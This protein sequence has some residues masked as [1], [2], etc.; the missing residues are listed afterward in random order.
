MNILPPHATRFWYAF[1]LTGLQFFA[2]YLIL[3]IKRTSPNER[4]DLMKSA[5]QTN[6]Q[7]E[8]NSSEMLQLEAVRWGDVIFTFL[9]YLIAVSPTLCKYNILFIFILISYTPFF[10]SLVWYFQ[11]VRKKM[12]FPPLSRGQHV[13][14]WLISLWIMLNHYNMKYSFIFLFFHLFHS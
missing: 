11:K 12:V 9:W 2:M 10:G 1:G 8:R 13:R 4:A 7:S 14:C 5:T 6:K 3:D